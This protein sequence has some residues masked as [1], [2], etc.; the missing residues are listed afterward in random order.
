MRY[1]IITIFIF[2][3]HS[4]LHKSNLTW[5][6]VLKFLLRNLKEHGILKLQLYFKNTS[7]KLSQYIYK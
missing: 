7:H 5:T 1:S 4:M 2:F 6:N 3:I